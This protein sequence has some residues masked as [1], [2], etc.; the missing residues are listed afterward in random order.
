MIYL[1]III[2][3]RRNI[4]HIAQFVLLLFVYKHQ[5]IFKNQ[6][7]SSYDIN[8]TEYAEKRQACVRVSLPCAFY[9]SL[10]GFGD[11]TIDK[12]RDRW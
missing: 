5:T 3:N 9:I 10:Y 11:L 7:M 4:L 1:S 2:Y 12:S 8:I 6:K